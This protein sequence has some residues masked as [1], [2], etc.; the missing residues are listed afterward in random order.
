MTYLLYGLNDY[1]IDTEIKK[2]KELN[3]I[4]SD[5]LINY[6][7]IETPLKIIIE[8]AYNMPLFNDKKL[9]VVNNCT[10]FESSSKKDETIILEK[11]LEKEND[12]TILIFVDKQEKLDERKKIFKFLKDNNKIIECNK[13]NINNLIKEELS[14]YEISQNSITKL[15][16]RVGTNPYNLINEINKL[17]IF[18]IN[19]K[20]ITEEDINF[21]SKNIEESIF[22]LID[23]IVNKNSEKTLEIYH[24]LLTK[25]SEPLAILILI[26]NQFRLILQCKKMYFQG[27]SEKDI[28]TILEIHP[29][30]VKLA[31]EKSRNY[32]EELLLKYIENLAD[33]D[34][35]IK[36]GVKDA[37]TGL[38]L[39]L[40]GI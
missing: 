23:Y 6:D 14:N 37:N 38:E 30:R 26:A 13:L 7:Y 39:F 40:L 32:S 28:A 17:K 27:F 10:L 15:I 20:K 18:K 11:Y 2:I 8:D 35:E 21:A 3:K 33:L 22:D 4:N 1:L 31:N 12:A 16:N 24:D 36:S 34:Y 29:Y 25:N 9:I 5:D 19:D